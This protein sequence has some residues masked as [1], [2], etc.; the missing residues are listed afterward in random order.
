MTH[1]VQGRLSPPSRATA[2]GTVGRLPSAPETLLLIY[3]TNLHEWRW[4]HNDKEGGREGKLGRNGRELEGRKELGRARQL[5]GE[6]WGGDR[7]IKQFRLTTLSQQPPRY[8]P[9]VIII[10]STATDCDIATF[11]SRLVHYRRTGDDGGGICFEIMFHCV[12]RTTFI[13]PL[14]HILIA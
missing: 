9:L 6:R 8:T 12:Y 1:G 4:K 3:A 11:T 10:G 14:L 7:D 5:H 13:K 2:A